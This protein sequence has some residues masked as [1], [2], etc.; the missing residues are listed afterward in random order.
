MSEVQRAVEIETGTTIIV[1]MIVLHW[2]KVLLVLAIVLV[3]SWARDAFAEPS[4]AVLR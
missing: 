4:W 2:P 3:A 1:L